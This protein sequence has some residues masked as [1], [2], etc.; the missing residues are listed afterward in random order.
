LFGNRWVFPADISGLLTN[1]SARFLKVENSET[2]SHF[3]GGKYRSQARTRRELA[4]RKS[5][6]ISV[7]QT[8]MIKSAIHKSFRAFGLDI[9]RVRRQQEDYPPDFQNEETDIIREVR[10]W[11]MTSPERIYS[12]IQAV[13]YVSAN[14]IEGAIVE[15]GVWKGG[16]M[17]AVART[18]LQIQDL[19]RD[20]FL[21]DTFEGMSEPTE[22]DIDYSGQ[23]ASNV[24]RENPSC[25]CADASLE[26]VTKL[27]HETGYSK[28]RVHFVKGR[29]EETIPSHAPDS[30]SLLRLDTDWYDST[31]HELVH[32]FPRLSDGGVI[33]I[34]DYG[35]WRG[36]RQACDE[37]FAQSR[38][39]ILLN[40]IDYT[41]RI[42]L[43]P[44]SS[45]TKRNPQDSS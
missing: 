33:I 38:I 44:F 31:K 39:P 14:A 7:K 42:A 21:F 11:T 2:D 3:P 9:T 24:M 6:R 18:L 28:E 32:L 40:R 20:L 17:A 45:A 10:P 4:G 23:Q 36:A 15:C 41:C 30:I 25:R 12:L 35:H 19:K 27:L 5:E 16:G 37:Y 8:T 22:K 13:R 43:K 34:D 26:S 29:V 1:R